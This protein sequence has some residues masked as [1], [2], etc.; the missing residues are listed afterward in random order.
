[1]DK[2]EKYVFPITFSLVG[3]KYNKSKI[4]GE[5]LEYYTGL[6][7]CG[8]HKIHLKIDEGIYTAF[9]ARTLKDGDVWIPEK[10]KL[11]SDDSDDF[12]S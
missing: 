9:K 10:T 5:V 3:V 4:D 7:I 1:M 8:G 2:N 12:E 11:V 6:A